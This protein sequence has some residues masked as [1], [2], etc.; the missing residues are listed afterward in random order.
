[1]DPMDHPGPTPLIQLQDLLEIG[2][3]SEEQT[4]KSKELLIIIPILNGMSQM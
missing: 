3:K 4:I 1:M 2:G